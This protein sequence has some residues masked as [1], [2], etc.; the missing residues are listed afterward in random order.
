MSQQDPDNVNNNSQFSNDG[1]SE[2][3]DENDDKGSDNGTQ[4]DRDNYT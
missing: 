3:F 4:N 2:N 1:L